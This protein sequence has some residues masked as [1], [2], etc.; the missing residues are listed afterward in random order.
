V[1]YFTRQTQG[2]EDAN[3][4]QGFTTMKK[5]NEIAIARKAIKA[6]I[7]KNEICPEQSGMHRVAMDAIRHLCKTDWIANELA[8]A[9]VLDCLTSH[10]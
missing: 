9:A 1:L 4:E 3:N 8:F 10:R 5:I 7:R 6:A 2:A